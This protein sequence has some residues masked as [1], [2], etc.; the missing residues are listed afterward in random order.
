MAQYVKNFIIQEQM[1][2]SITT[3]VKDYIVNRWPSKDILS[4]ELLEIWQ[5][6]ESL[7]AIEGYLVMST[8]IF[9]PQMYIHSSNVKRENITD[10]SRCSYGIEQNESSGRCYS[11]VADNRCRY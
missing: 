1:S 10:T 4:P 3:K 5:R 7:A 11:V 9:I 6:R 2:D 8:R